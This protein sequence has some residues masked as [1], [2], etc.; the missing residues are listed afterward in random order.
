MSRKQIN[1]RLPPDL[2][3]DAKARGSLTEVIEAALR[4]HLHGPPEDVFADHERRISALE[5]LANRY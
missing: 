1:V 2:I 4:A 5:E 3:S